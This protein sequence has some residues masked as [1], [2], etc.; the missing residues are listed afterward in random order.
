[1]SLAG[2]AK[3]ES[4]TP[5]NPD[6]PTIAEDAG[7]I[8][9]TLKYAAQT[10]ANGDYENGSESESKV[11]DLTIYFFDK[12]KQY[13]GL[14]EAP[15]LNQQQQ[16]IDGNVERSVIAVEVPAG[17]VSG[18]Y[19]ADNDPSKMT[20]AYVVAV[21]NKGVFAPVLTSVEDAAKNGGTVSTYA[22]FNTMISD[23]TIG[24]VTE[25]GNFLMTSSNYVI[26]GVE[27][28]LLK[29]TKENV[30]IK[31]TSLSKEPEKVTIA[32]ERVAAKVRVEKK[33]NANLDV[34]GWGLNVTNKKFYPVKKFT[35]GF[36]D[37]LTTKYADWGQNTAWNNSDDMRSYWAVDPNYTEGSVEEDG[38]SEDFELLDYNSLIGLGETAYC[39][40]NTFSEAMQNRNSTTSAII[41]AKFNPMGT[42]DG[43][44]VNWKQQNFSEGDFVNTVVGNADGS[45]K[46][47]TKY[48]YRVKN[49][50]AGTV[51]GGY[52]VGEYLYCP[53]GTAEFQFSFNGTE[54]IKFGEVVIGKKGA[55][56]SVELTKDFGAFYT[57]P[58]NENDNAAW[59]AN[60]VEGAEDLIAAAITAA[61]DAENNPVTVYVG[62]YSYYEVPLRHFND[63]E[64]AQY[65]G[66]EYEPEHL[67]RYGIVRNNY[68]VLTINAITTPGKPISDKPIPTKKKDDVEE[69]YID[70]EIQVLS[71]N[72]R[73][74]EVEL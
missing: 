21:L 65:A 30:G 73:N 8:N 74:Q 53:L 60:E 59:E 57:K 72:V 33:A 40:E 11:T 19:A 26:D 13:L 68:Y 42:G 16:P 14:G 4:G 55:N 66:G 6:N 67:G 56:A 17:V 46:N 12:D 45:E 64:V 61:I 22:D 25:A 23:K 32:V 9:V 34:L 36:L 28:A 48:Y 69:Y 49:P 7:T 20:E 37:V 39:F 3:D 51:V 24:T 10:R 70:T 63:D 2:C 41:V 5:E 44:W 27:Q 15:K 62:G 38:I 35:N 1:M 18:F 50:D 47:I 54:E 31:S 29:I 43:T 71:W 52:T 58:A